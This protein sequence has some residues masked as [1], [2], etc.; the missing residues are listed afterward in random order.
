MIYEHQ[1]AAIEKDSQKFNTTDESFDL[2]LLVD[3]L[4]SER[5]QGITI[6]VAYR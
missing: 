6:D 4:Q 3:G 1:M 5:E 2:A